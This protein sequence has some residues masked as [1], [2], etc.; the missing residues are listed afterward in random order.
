M[1]FK[2]TEAKQAY[3]KAYYEKNKLRIN[4]ERIAKDIK[5]NNQRCIMHNA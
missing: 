1:P 4:A 5:E 3:N 2:S